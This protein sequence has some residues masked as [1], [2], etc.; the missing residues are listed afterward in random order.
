MVPEIKTIGI[1]GAGQMG[2][3]IAHVCA[4]AGYDVHM[5][6]LDQKVLERALNLIDQ[7][8]TR[9]VAREGGAEVV[10]LDHVSA[11]HALCSAHPWM[12]GAS[13]DMAAHDGVPYHPTAAGM[14]GAAL[15]IERQID[16]R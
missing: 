5:S 2:S 4:L 16:R 6:D 12:N 7:N 14:A 13:P 11:P 3:G 10:P 8:M 15:A 9:Q 1:V